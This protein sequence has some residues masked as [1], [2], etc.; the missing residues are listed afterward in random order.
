MCSFGL[1]SVGLSRVGLS[2]VG[3]SSVGL[4]SVGL[5]GD[6]TGGR[7]RCQGTRP[8]QAFFFSLVADYRC[9]VFSISGG[10][11][12]SGSR[13]CPAEAEDYSMHALIRHAPR[14]TKKAVGSDTPRLC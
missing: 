6:G 3:L 10:R 4:S 12:I 1:S 5:E 11:G 2:S 9:P 14:K 13:R 8:R 7:D